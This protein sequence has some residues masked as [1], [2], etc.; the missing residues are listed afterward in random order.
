MRSLGVLALA[1]VF[2]AC[3]SLGLGLGDERAVVENLNTPPD[4]ILRIAMTQL[5]HHGFGVAQLSDNQV[6]TTPMPVPDYIRQASDGSA[7]Q[8]YVIRVSTE[9]ARFLAGSRLVVEGFLLPPEAMVAQANQ[10]HQNMIPVTGAT[11]PRLFD[12]VET[13]AGWIVDASRR[14]RR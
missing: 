13:V 11:H 12:Q 2:S 5:E 9:P 6:I 3:A 1:Y 4:T 7:P 10:V 14:S 8:Q